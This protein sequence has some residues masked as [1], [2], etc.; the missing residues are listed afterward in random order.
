MSA[1]QNLS[2]EGVVAILWTFTAAAFL[3]TIGRFAIH[4]RN[5][6]KFVWD[7][8]LN[9]CA[10]LALLV[11]GITYQVVGAPNYDLQFRNPDAFEKSMSSEPKLRRM[12]DVMIVGFWC[13]IYFVKASFLALYWTL[14]AL[15]QKF[16]IAWWI[17]TAYTFFTFAATITWRWV[18]IFTAN[19]S[20]QHCIDLVLGWAIFD[21]FGDIL[22][23]V[24]PLT[25]L[26]PLRMR[27]SQKIGLGLIFGLVVINIILEILRTVL[28]VVVDFKRFQGYGEVGFILQATL[29]VITCALPCYRG[30]M[31]KR[32][33]VPNWS[34]PTIAVDVDVED[35]DDSE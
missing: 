29:A 26:S 18:L 24:L 1:S 12:N 34:L 10:L 3:L 25:M 28:L 14:F 15:S 32:K 33:R 5:G 7:D 4:W 13:V 31:I 11:F 27:I 19:T 22:L 9:G 30:L 8:I 17:V 21:I 2:S 20:D 6:K 16:R 35:K 23:M